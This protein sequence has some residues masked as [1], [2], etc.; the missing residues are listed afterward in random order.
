[1]SGAAQEIL[2]QEILAQELATL[3]FCWRLER[4]DGRRAAI[5]GTCA[6]IRRS[7]GQTV[8]AVLVFQ[9]VSEKRILT[10]QLARSAPAPL[11]FPSMV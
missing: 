4:R 7:D 1:M 2:A 11:R 5:E 9:D 10:L 3:A 8:G 6:P